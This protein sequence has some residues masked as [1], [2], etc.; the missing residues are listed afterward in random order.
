MM[1]LGLADNEGKSGLCGLMWSSKVD[2]TYQQSED[3]NWGWGCGTAAP[4]FRSS[5]A[6]HSFERKVDSDFEGYVKNG[7]ILGMMKF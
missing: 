7:I 3:G 5:G 6:I 2:L 4:S 1:I